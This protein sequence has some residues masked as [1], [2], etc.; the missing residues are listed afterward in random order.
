MSLN[1]MPPLTFSAQPRYYA[2]RIQ[3]NV[4]FSVWFV[5]LAQPKVQ[6][7][8]SSIFKAFN[9]NSIENLQIS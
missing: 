3:H 9:I 7:Y 8:A 4:T 2:W 1:Q 5:L 6:H